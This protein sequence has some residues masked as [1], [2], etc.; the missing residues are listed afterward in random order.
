M[1]PSRATFRIA[2]QTNRSCRYAQV[3]LEVTARSALAE[4]PAEVEVTADSFDEY[5]REAV[6]GVR[7]ALRYLPQPA[8]VTVTDIVTTEIDT[9]VGDVYEAA[10]HAVWQAVQADDH[11]RFVG[12]TDRTMVADWLA[13]M[14]GRRLESVTEARAWF[15]G[16]REGGDAESLV[17][18]WL[19]FEHAVPIALHCLDEHLILVHE[20]PYEPYA[21][22]GFG[23]TRVGPARSP[24]LLAGF[25]GS[26][27]LGSDVL[28]SL[29]GENICGGLVLHFA[30][31]GRTHEGPTREDLVIGARRDEWVLEAK[32]PFA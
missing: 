28:P 25:A 13:R 16:H 1:T 12:F 22:A 18:A 4:D 3:T 24:D 21:M 27:L 19:F 15:E 2:Q 17:H 11:P 10:A 23:E 20:K 31:E 7:W 9:G 5:R 29:E 32:R 6:L 8:R 26:R 30:H 14:H